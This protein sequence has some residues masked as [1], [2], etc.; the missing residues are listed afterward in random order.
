MADLIKSED[1]PRW[2]PGVVTHSSA[3]RGWRG[4]TVRGYRYLGQEVQIPPMRDFMIVSYQRGAT[5]MERR[6]D[7]TWTKARCAPGSISL[8]TRAQRSEWT[9]HENIDVRHVYLTNEF[10]TNLASEALDKRIDEVVLRDLLNIDDPVITD[11]ATAL[12]AEASTTSMGGSM[13]AEAVATQLAL[14]LLRTYASVS[15][16]AFEDKARLTSAQAG[17]MSDFITAHLA[18]PISVDMLARE[19][20]LGACRFAE[21][22]R[23]T[24]GCAP[25]AYVL[26]RR[27]EC[28]RELIETSSL[29]LKQIAPACGF[30]DQAHMNRVFKSCYGVTPGRVRRERR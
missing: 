13:Y 9:W 14:H 1:L 10:I 24:F 30:N 4:V 27:A 18:D 3:D 8:H 21:R 23:E 5:P 6:F 29:P 20:G 16:G 7:G 26:R 12:S 28:A 11:A 22:F 15:I 17:R 19:C 2:V 25:Y